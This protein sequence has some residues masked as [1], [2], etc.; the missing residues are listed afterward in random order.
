M[1]APL[2]THR[3][4]W[5]WINRERAIELGIRNRI[6]LW[7]E[8]SRQWV[9]G[10]SRA[11]RENKQLWNRSVEALTTR[12]ELTSKLFCAGMMSILQVH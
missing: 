8:Q 12:H 2:M 10:G 9:G 6:S 3:I 7:N 11:S 4:D 5:M 1:M